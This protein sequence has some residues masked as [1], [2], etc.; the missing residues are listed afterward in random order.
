MKYYQNTLWT[1]YQYSYTCI[2]QDKI[3]WK[4]TYPENFSIETALAQT[5]TTYLLILGL[6][7]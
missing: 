1:K 5:M 3:V 4:F 6:N 7:G 2:I